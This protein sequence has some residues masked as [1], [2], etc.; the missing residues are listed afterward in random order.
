MASG[1]EDPNFQNTGAKPKTSQVTSSGT[2]NP[3]PL[4][5]QAQGQTGEPIA[6]GP[7]V[8]QPGPPKTFADAAA[9]GLDP[10]K[11][12]QRRQSVTLKCDEVAFM[13]NF[14]HLNLQPTDSM[15]T[16]NL[17]KSTADSLVAQEQARREA[18][19]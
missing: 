14:A 11:G 2:S 8:N 6:A 19:F 3:S 13:K 18:I 15:E 16:Q 5:Q 10:S 1:Q 12:T 9:T 4:N 17:K 7:Q